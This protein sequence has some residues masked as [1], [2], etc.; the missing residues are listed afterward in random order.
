MCHVCINVAFIH[1]G[2]LPISERI[3]MTHCQLLVPRYEATKR[4]SRYT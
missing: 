3:H 4:L 2:F 1:P